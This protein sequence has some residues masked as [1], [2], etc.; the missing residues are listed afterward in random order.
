MTNSGTESD[1]SD[2]N[3]DTKPGKVPYNKEPEM[4]ETYLREYC[5][6][7]AVEF[8]HGT[9]RNITSDD[10]IGTAKKFADYL[11]GNDEKE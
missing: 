6:G 2:S 5:L 7:K 3:L 1:P 4:P 8:Y 9:P 11:R 10:V